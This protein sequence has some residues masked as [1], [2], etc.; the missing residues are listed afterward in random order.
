MNF[1]RSTMYWRVKAW[2]LLAFALVERRRQQ[3]A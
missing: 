2:N 3:I 1:L